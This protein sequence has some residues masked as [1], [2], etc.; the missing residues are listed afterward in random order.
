MDPTDQL[1]RLL[2]LAAATAGLAVALYS[3]AWV[4]PA[5]RAIGKR[6]TAGKLPAWLRLLR[7]HLGCAFCQCAVAALLLLPWQPAG[8]VGYLATAAAAAWM[9]RTVALCSTCG[10]A[11]PPA[12]SP[13]PAELRTPRPFPMPPDYRGPAVLDSR[14]PAAP[15][16][17]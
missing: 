13:N 8:V 9:H 4:M 1:A 6:E 10:A 16:G 17:D 15:A 7:Y 3:P 14:P 5:L 11:R 2:P 12:P